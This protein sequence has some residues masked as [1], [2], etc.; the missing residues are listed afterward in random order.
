MLKCIKNWKRRRCLASATGEREREWPKEMF[1]VVIRSWLVMAFSGKEG[2]NK[3]KKKN[4]ERME[5]G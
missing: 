1:D 3:T 5:S 4:V 2:P